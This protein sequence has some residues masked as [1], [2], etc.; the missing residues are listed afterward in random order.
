MHS[1][2]ALNRH[3]GSGALQLAGALSTSCTVSRTIEAEMSVSNH[4]ISRC[5]VGI[6]ESPYL[7]VF[8]C[9]ECLVA[10]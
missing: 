10:V 4:S 8:S 2:R 1:G 7:S 5:K 3:D 6:V 9:K